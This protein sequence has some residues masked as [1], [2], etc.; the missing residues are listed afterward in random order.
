VNRHKIVIATQIFSM[1]QAS[2]LAALTLT[3]T[4]AVWHIVTLSVVLG[5]INA[6]DIPARQ[7]F[8][9]EMIEKKEDLGN[10]IALNSSMFN[11]ARL[12]GPSIAGFV[13]AAVGEGICFLLNAVSFIG[14]LMA[15][16]AMNIPKREQ[17]SPALGVMQGFKEGLRYA[18]GLP[19]IKYILLL[20][21]LISMMGMPYTVLMPIIT[22]DI[23]HGGAQTLGFLMGS[24]G[25]GALTGALY[26]ASR[27]NV[28]GLSRW[29]GIAAGIFGV[30]LVGFS[31]SSFLWLSMAL[32]FVTGF[33]MM[34]QIASSNTILQTI[35]DDDKRGRVMSLYTMSF[36]GMAPFGSLLA[37]S[38][39]S[40]IGAPHTL[41]ISG[42]VCLLAA[43][44]FWIKLP[45]LRKAIRP[46]YVRIGII[47]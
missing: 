31:L 1:V 36:M 16:L 6:V 33:G 2:I 8:L 37:G 24:I 15:L 29:I 13:I 34:V 27:K 4:I 10:A 41:L 25:V 45:V 39:A 28:L 42:I 19:P 11:G 38:L 12:I 7:S 30:G 35:V 14:V 17:K 43:A 18:F 9:L 20:L 32:L 47:P 5:I 40:K 44:L 23:L 46:I 3:G 26:L 22:K 21:A